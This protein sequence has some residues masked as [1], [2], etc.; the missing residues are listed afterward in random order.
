[1]NWSVQGMRIVENAAEFH[2]KLESAKHEAIASFGDDAFLLNPEWPEEFID[3]CRKW[4]SYS[5]R[6]EPR[7]RA[8]ICDTVSDLIRIGVSDSQ[9]LFPLTVDM[10]SMIS[11]SAL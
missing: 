6:K 3:G 11:L 9:L 5:Q 1:M 10:D 7:I 8:A 2:E 4:R